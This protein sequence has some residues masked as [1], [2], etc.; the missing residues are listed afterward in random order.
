MDEWLLINKANEFHYFKNIKSICNYLNLTKSE[1][2]NIFIQSIKN[3]N[4]YTNKGFYIQRLFNDPTKHIR[5]KF[6]KHKYAEYKHL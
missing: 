3:T 1:V 6:E 5:T 2:N 4:K